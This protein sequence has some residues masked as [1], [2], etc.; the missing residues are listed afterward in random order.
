MAKRR[1]PRRVVPAPRPVSSPK[2]SDGK[3]LEKG[4]VI[5]ET[6]D[7]PALIDCKIIGETSMEGMTRV[8]ERF[9]GGPDEETHL[10]LGRFGGLGECSLPLSGAKGADAEIEVSLPNPFPGDRDTRRGLQFSNEEERETELVFT[11]EDVAG[12]GSFGR[13]H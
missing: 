8:V 1:W 11:P 12:S 5:H 7:D 6:L 4:E 3:S 13:M 9:V 10:Q 2:V